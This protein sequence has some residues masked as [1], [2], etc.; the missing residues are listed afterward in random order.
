[1]IFL[2]TTSQT[3]EVNPSYE[4]Q[5]QENFPEMF[6]LWEEMKSDQTSNDYFIKF[7]LYQETESGFTASDT[8]NGLLINI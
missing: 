2:R 7:S 4:K 5:Y 6:S 3:E 8:N 1:M